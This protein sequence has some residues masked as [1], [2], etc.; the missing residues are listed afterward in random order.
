VTAK[1]VAMLCVF[2]GLTAVLAATPVLMERPAEAGT[3]QATAAQWPRENPP[4]PLPTKPATFPSYELRKLANGLQVVLVSQNEQPSIS[5]RM[6]IRAG[7]AHDPKAKHGLA[8]MAATLLDQGA[9]S[10]T[11]EEIAEQIDFIGGALGT[12]A[13]TD[14]TYVN[15]VVMNDSYNIALDLVSDVVLRPTFA[16]EEIERQRAQALSALKVAA[17]DPDSVA[18][19]VI[20]R[21]IYGFHPY[22]MPGNGTPESLSKLTRQDFVDYHRT[23]FV[24][25]NA[26]IAIVGDI[27]AA[28]AMAGLEKHFGAWKPADVPAVAV[29]DP[30]D[31]TRRVIVVDKKDSVQTEIRVGHIAIPRKHQDFEAVDQAVKILG[32]EGANRLQQVL[33]SQKQLTYGASADLDTYKMAGAVIAETDTQTANTAEALRVVVDEFTRLQRERVYDEELESAQAYM[34]GHFPLTIEVPDAIATQVLNQL[35]YELPVEDLPRFRERV[36]KVTP[37]EIQRV[38]RWFIRPSQLSVVLVG[39]AD[40]FIKDLKGVGFGSFE[41]V[42]IEQLDLLSVDF[43]KRRAGAH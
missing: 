28:D 7:A 12:G 17:E 25:N 22:G 15:A 33:R 2:S 21:L 10:R 11:A 5:V 23:Y 30:P 3:G 36:L 31:A 24:P 41:R 18:G 27:S 39:D 16:P 8:M 26:L 43:L 42:P 9:G 4:R 29:T 6:I 19:Q 14:L 13:G 20:D 35:F 37:D 32:G 40:K 34:V 38:A 1:A